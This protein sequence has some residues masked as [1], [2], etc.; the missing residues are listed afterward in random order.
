VSILCLAVPPADAEV[1]VKPKDDGRYRVEFRYVAPAG[2]RSVSVAGEFNEWRPDQLTLAGPDASGTWTT[3]V[4]LAAGRYEYKYFVNGTQWI[5]DPD[6]PHTAGEFGNSVVFVGIPAPTPGVQLPGPTPRPSP[7]PAPAASLDDLPAELQELSR[8]LN[9]ASNPDPVGEASAWLSAYAMPSFDA[10]HCSFVFQAPTEVTPSL[11]FI[12]RGREQRM[13]MVQIAPKARLFARSFVTEQLPPEVAYHYELR[14]GDQSI[15]ILDP[16]AWSVTSRNG[17][18]ANAVVRPGDRAGRIELIPGVRPADGSLMPRDIYVYLPPGYDA[19]P[20]RRYPVLYLHDGQNCWDDPVD[21]FGRGGWRINRIADRAIAQGEI[22][23]FI[24]VAA[25]NTPDRLNEYTPGRNMADGLSHPYLRFLLTELKPAIDARY[26]TLP[27]ATHTAM[28][29]ASLGG[30]I[31]FQ[32]AMTM[33]DR[34]GA[35]VC[36]SSSFMFPDEGKLTYR[37]LVK[38][39]GKVNVRL[40]VDHGTGG[41][42]QDGAPFSREVVAALREAGWRDGADFEYFEDVGAT[43]DEHAW[44]KRVPRVLRFLYGRRSP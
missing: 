3:A 18:P 7:T 26:R 24:G 41:K 23:P 10:T 38:R 5:A 34:I 1:A 29:G 13:A 2:T 32:A 11:V 19:E 22:E 21:P 30:S 4:V 17:R 14:K 39:V 37:E 27:D 40:Y 20:E 28:M 33:P 43:H 44:R 6:N 16:Y 36:M 8:R 9:A 12:V 35:A 31:S 25:A 42:G 15:A